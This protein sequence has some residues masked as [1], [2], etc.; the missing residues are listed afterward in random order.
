MEKISTPTNLRPRYRFFSFFNM[1]YATTLLASVV[2]FYK[3]VQLGHATVVGS[4]ICFPMSYIVGDIIAEVYGYGAARQLIWFGLICVYI[5]CLFSSAIVHLP[6]PAFWHHQA[7]YATVLGH[8]LQFCISATAA[9]LVGEFLNAY[10]ISKW[11]IL[12]RGRLFWL[13]SLGSTA[14]G[15]IANTLVM[16]LVGF[17]GII[18]MPHVG[19]MMFCA[20][21]LKMSYAIIAVIPAAALVKYIKRKESIDVYDYKTNFNPFRL[22]SL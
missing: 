1:L 11:K 15:Q 7:A 8:N 20:Y 17:A 9:I 2:L 22:G 16:Y 14:L 13:R 5:F 18:A 6:H 10:I 12:I 21:S 3:P 19:W 4:D